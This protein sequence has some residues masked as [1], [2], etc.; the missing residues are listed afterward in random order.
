MGATEPQAA[1]PIMSSRGL[2]PGRGALPRSA[3]QREARTA[4]P[5][6]E[7]CAPASRPALWARLARGAGL[8]PAAAASRDPG[9]SAA[10]AARE[11]V[12]GDPSH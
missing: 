6:Q 4:L 9:S 2:L 12:G 7:A 1:A 8:R 5:G 10:L 3:T 11:E